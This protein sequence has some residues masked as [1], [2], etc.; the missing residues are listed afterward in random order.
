MQ[1]AVQ[2]PLHHNA[3]ES[4]CSCC[5]GALAAGHA[6]LVPAAL[7]PPMHPAP[8]HL[9]HDVRCRPFLS[10]RAHVYVW[11][12]CVQVR[13]WVLRG[14]PLWDHPWHRDA[15]GHPAPGPAGPAGHDAAPAW[16]QRRRRGRRG[17]ARTAW[18]SGGGPGAAG[19][20]WRARRLGGTLVRAS[21]GAPN[22]SQP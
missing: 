14:A 21:A 19:P 8:C 20:A 13:D 1:R 3:L 16:Q 11:C 22:M 15:P 5:R 9:L 12:A 10:L 18:R 7:P 2:G 6:V 4:A 17:A